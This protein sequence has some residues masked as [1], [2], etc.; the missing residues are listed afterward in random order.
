M[1]KRKIKFIIV[2]I[3]VFLSGL[4]LYHLPQHRQV[5][6]PVCNVTGETVLIEIDVNYYRRLFSKPWIEGTVT[7]DGEIYQDSRTLWGAVNAGEDRSYWDWDWDFKIPSNR[8]PGNLQFH[9]DSNDRLKAF[10]DCLRFYNIGSK[11]DFSY[12]IFT[13]SNHELNDVVKYYGPAEDIEDA[14]RVA[15]SLGWS[16]D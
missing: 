8:L 3:C 12:V 16:F 5:S 11:H 7:F 1:K 15:E 14:R 2:F 10:Y 4:V 9:K 13:Y 6:M